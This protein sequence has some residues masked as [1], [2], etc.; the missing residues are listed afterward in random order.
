MGQP[1]NQAD[2][3]CTHAFSV[4]DR[5]SSAFEQFFEICIALA[6]PLICVG[7]FISSANV[8]PKLRI[9]YRIFRPDWLKLGDFPAPP[10]SSA[11]SAAAEASHSLRLSL[12]TS[13]ILRCGDGI[14]WASGSASPQVGLPMANLD[15]ESP[16][17]KWRFSLTKGATK[18]KTHAINRFEQTSEL[19]GTLRSPYALCSHQQLFHCLAVG[20]VLQ[21][22]ERTLQKGFQHLRVHLART[23][24][25]FNRSVLRLLKMEAQGSGQA[26]CISMWQKPLGGGMA[27]RRIFSKTSPRSSETCSTSL[28]VEHWLL[29]KPP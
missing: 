24:Q 26:Q 17:Q 14:R 4:C 3:A 2:E 1:W 8:P 28:W 12:G 22:T 16:D 29:C 20:A 18:K 13:N 10:N 19:P 11:L 27:F 7:Y 25:E 23:P 21:R 6:S 9:L 15:S 5:Y